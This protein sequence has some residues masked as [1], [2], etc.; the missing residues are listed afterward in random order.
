MP[1]LFNSESHTKY[2]FG[3]GFNAR[4]TRN[5]ILGMRLTFD[6]TPRHFSKLGGSTGEAVAVKSYLLSANEGKS[7][8]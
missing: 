5:E 2:S 3:R 1:N 8:V 6:D 4:T 7:E